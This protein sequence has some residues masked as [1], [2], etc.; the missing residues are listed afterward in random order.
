MIIL[1]FALENSTY[2]LLHPNPI[3]KDLDADPISVHKR[4][5]MSI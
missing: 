4:I 3:N 1:P 2:Y 5:D